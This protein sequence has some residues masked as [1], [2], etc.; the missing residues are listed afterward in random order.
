MKVRWNTTLA[1]LERAQLLQPAFDAFVSE[2]PNGLTEKAKKVAQ[3]RKKKWEMSSGDW[4]FIDKLVRALEVLKLVTLEFSKKT[5]PTISK[6][7]LYK[8]MEVTLTN[9]AT[10][11]NEEEPNLSAALRA[12]AEMATKYISKAL[13]GDYV[14]LGAGTTFSPPEHIHILTSYS[15]L[16]PAVR[17][18]FFQG[19][20]WDPSIAIRARKLLLNMV[21]KYAQADQRTSPTAPAAGSIQSTST[22]TVFAM[23]M[24]LHTVPTSTA[25]ATGDGRDEVELYFGNISPVAPDFD[26]PLAW[27]KASFF[28]AAPNTLLNT[29]KKI[30]AL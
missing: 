25:T 26:D 16:H 14:L 10:T 24:A 13:Y 17:L 23:A 29:T 4:E 11:F 6:V 2:L 21:K 8:L 27:W 19:R 1:E 5:V 18:A 28:Y 7:L 3:A 15:I 30:Q 22:T 20:Q 12:G 9:L